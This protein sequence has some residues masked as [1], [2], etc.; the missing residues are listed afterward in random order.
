MKLQRSKLNIKNYLWSVDSE[1][2]NICPTS[3][4]LKTVCGLI[5]IYLQLNYHQISNNF[6]RQFLVIDTCNFT[7]G[8]GRTQSIFF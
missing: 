7:H 1:N 4:I 6:N 8:K 2:N 3:I 5:Q